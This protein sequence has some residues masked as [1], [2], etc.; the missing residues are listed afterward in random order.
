M[1]KIHE[2]APAQWHCGAGIRE[3]VIPTA[4]FAPKNKKRRRSLGCAAVNSSRRYWEAG[5]Y[6]YI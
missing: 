6:E 1:K 2:C 4:L 5:P 3:Q